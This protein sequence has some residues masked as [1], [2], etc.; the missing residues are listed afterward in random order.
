MI[1]G[2]LGSSSISDGKLNG[3]EITFKVGNA[4]YT[5]RVNGNRMEGTVGNERWSAV[6]AAR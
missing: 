5:G 1:S 2:T 6:R 4:L 3:T